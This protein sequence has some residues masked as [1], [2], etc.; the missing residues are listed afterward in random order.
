[1]RRRDKEITDQ[2]IIN[3]ILKSNTVCRI[4]LCDNGTPYI[5]PMN[6]GFDEGNIYLHC[7]KEGKKI[8]I[9]EANN[10]VCFEVTDS[11]ETVTSDKACGFGTRYRSVIGQGRV[12][13]L[14][15]TEEKIKVLNTIMKQHTG[16]SDWDF[17]SA[18]VDKITVLKITT[19]SI[20]GKISGF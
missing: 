16:K 11:V 6:Y 2:K 3:Q 7:A 20:T 13:H 9:I 12:D 5:V 10:R 4:A 8:E 15:L 1:M 18:V 14:T 19:E 17:D